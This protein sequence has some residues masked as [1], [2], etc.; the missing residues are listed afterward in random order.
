M[1]RVY[2]EYMGDSIEIPPGETV[3]GRGVGCALR[4]NDP[5]V[6]RR[7]LRFIRRDHN[8]YVEDLGSN[9]G[10]LLNGEPVR[11]PTAL[12]PG[13]IVKVGSRELT[14][15]VVAD[16]EKE[17]S[18][19]EDMPIEEIQDAGRARTRPIVRIPDVATAMPAQR[20]PRCGA[21]VTEQD[22]EC[23]TCHFRW[24]SFRPMVPTDVGANPMNRRRADRA[25]V[26]LHL[27]Y[28]SE[29]LELEALSRDLSATGV[30]VCT[31]VLDAVGTSCQLTILLDGGPPVHA[32]GVV[33]RVVERYE[34]GKDP[35]GFGVEFT[36][37]AP[38]DRAW[39]AAVA[40]RAT[41]SKPD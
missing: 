41:A 28:V 18:T 39:L 13:D 3:V 23:E 26:E 27:V 16:E 14:M 29:E 12:R 4:F 24:G 1:R 2:I 8:V 7:H 34:E 22:D 32:R 40:A 30:Y 20:C 38:D 36:D 5:A 6:S 17:P 9:N 25:P 19:L 10:T 35:V 11:A 21:G 31:E 33:R 15:S 37:I